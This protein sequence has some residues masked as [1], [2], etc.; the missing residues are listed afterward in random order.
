[1][2]LESHTLE[3]ALGNGDGSP[4]GWNGGFTFLRAGPLS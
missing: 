1:M 4:F 3:D 2:Y